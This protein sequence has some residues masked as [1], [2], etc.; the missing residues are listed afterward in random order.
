MSFDIPSY[1]EPSI[2]RFAQAQR[3]TH[4]EAIIR[5]IQFGLEH[6]LPPPAAR[7][8][9]GIFSSP[10]DSAAIDDAMTIAMKER[11]RRNG[12]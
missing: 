1:I 5:L 6:A 3:I 10:E 9:L 2:E 7:E 11:E 4:D 12:R 8:T